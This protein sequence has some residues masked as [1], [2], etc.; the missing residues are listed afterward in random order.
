[1]QRFWTAAV[2]N[3]DGV[4][5]VGLGRKVVLL[6]NLLSQAEVDGSL[7]SRSPLIATAVDF[8]DRLVQHSAAVG[9]YC[10]VILQ[11]GYLSPAMQ[12]L[13]WDL[14]YGILNKYD[15]SEHLTELLQIVYKFKH[16]F[17]VEKVLGLLLNSIHQ[18]ICNDNNIN[19]FNYSLIESILRDTGRELSSVKVAKMAKALLKSVQCNRGFLHMSLQRSGRSP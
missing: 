9:K 8:L 11:S 5:E 1:M 17:G 12:K 10:E 15:D 16:R 19:Q 6:F 14:L 18:N 4:I 7:D 2:C 3:I 13:V